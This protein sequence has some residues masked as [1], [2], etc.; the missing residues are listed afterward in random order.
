[1]FEAGRLA[2][3]GLETAIELGGIFGHLGHAL[4]TAQLAYQSG[5][6]PSGAAGQLTALQQ[7]HVGNAELG[8]MIGDRAT[9]DAAADDDNPR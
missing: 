1:M 2:G 6:V 7:H 9:D 8:Q 4:R 5:G 3:L